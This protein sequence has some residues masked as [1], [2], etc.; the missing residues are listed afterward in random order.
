MTAAGKSTELR[1]GNGAAPSW[2]PFVQKSFEITEVNDTLR[3]V[4]GPNRPWI[5]HG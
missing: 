5:S 3:S 1:E 2:V 4:K